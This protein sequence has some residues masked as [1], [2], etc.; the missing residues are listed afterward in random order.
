MATTTSTPQAILD[1]V[2]GAENITHLT[3][4]A[5]R[6]RF[7][8]KDASVVDKAT[9]EKIPG[10][11][12][13]VP[14]SGDRYQ[15]IIGGAVQSVYNDI[16]KLPAMAGGASSSAK[17]DADIK[18]AA[19]AKARGKNAY[20]DAFFEY[21]SDAFRP[22][23]PVLL[24]ASLILALIA[25]LEA[26]GVVDTHAKV[27]PS[28]LVFTNTMWRSVFYFLPAMVAY[29]AAK[30]LD[31]DPWVGAAVVLALLTPEYTSLKTLKETHCIKSSVGSDLCTTD[32]F[33]LPMK[34]SDYGGQVFLP[35]IMVPI[36]A[37]V[38]RGLKKVIPA[39]VQ[40]VFVPFFS[41]LVMIPVSAF[42]IGP[43]SLWLG[44]SIGSGLSWLNTTA[45][46]VFAIFIP[47]LYPFLVPLGLHW[48][49][50]ALQLANIAGPAHA[51]FIQGPMGTWNFACFGAT[52]GVLI[53]TLRNGDK[54]LRQTASGALAAGLFGGISEPS[55]Y[56]IHLRFK[57]IYPLMLTG[58]A[59]GGLT[60][61]V[62]S[63]ISGSPVLTGT[64]VFTS[65]LTIPVFHPTV[66]YAISIAVAF[67]VSAFMV[68]TFG[69]QSK[70]EK[71]AAAAEQQEAPEAEAAAPAEAAPKAELVAG[72]EVVLTAPL[73]GTVVALE[74][75]PD[76]VFSSGAVGK[77]AGIEPSDG[78]SIKVVAPADGS[79][80]VAPS[81]GHAY[82]LAL[83]NGLEILIHVGIDTVNLAGQGFDVKVAK[84][85]RVKAGQTLVVVDRAVIEEA[86]YKLVTPV[87]VTNYMNFAEVEVI[88]SG[89]IETG[90]DL[91]KAT[92]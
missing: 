59:A 36:L 65:L 7:E 83:D 29:N 31:I 89:D 48:P 16:M 67:F 87:L 84:G 40:M 72:Q 33:G 43:F 50:N 20:V 35:L 53:L 66:T 74:D 27:L 25:V 11:M 41:F 79:V 5:T 21:L 69:Y 42:L 23:L 55:L 6:L 38:Y 9:V 47:L 49:L 15:I 86:G 52:L 34:W 62:I 58:C 28:W 92:K 30:K 54:E 85:D 2:G 75:V 12:G 77:G 78:A 56:G 18:A 64:F 90:A 26:F 76:P 44:N 63:W 91:V 1:A 80:V 61:G 82:G 3:H 45:P 39:N 68:V 24:G 32:I 60:I 22:L 37:L 51:D 17:S 70:E 57:R 4:C 13:A 19:R 81:S 46:I 8:L 88:A 10:V 73:N 71:E 14:Q